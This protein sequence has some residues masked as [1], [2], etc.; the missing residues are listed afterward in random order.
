[1][2]DYLYG[3][4]PTG[5]YRGNTLGLQD[6]V[7]YIVDSGSVLVNVEEGHAKYPL[8]VKA[9]QPGDDTVLRLQGAGARGASRR[10]GTPRP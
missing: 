2:L 7:M 4:Q 10:A 1:M 6:G 8:E 3:L 5:W 9:S